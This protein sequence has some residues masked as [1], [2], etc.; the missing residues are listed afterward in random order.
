MD[1]V[2]AMGLKDSVL[3]FDKDKVKQ[4]I[5]ES[6]RK[7]IPPLEMADVLT[8]AI[9]EIGEGLQRGDMF[10]PE[11]M[12][13]AKTVS[14]GMDLLEQ[15]LTR[16]GQKRKILGRVVI[17]TVRGDLHD[18]G[19]NMVKTLM[20][21]NGFEVLDLGVNV[22]HSSFVE[23]A[24]NTKPNILAMSAL[25]TTTVSEMR[26]VIHALEQAG[27]RRELKVMVGGA[28]VTKEFANEIAADG[29]EPTATLAVEL[30][31]TLVGATAPAAL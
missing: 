11:L 18:I 26:K 30:A 4:L 23:A 3:K 13:G 14:S 17:G 15:E 16:R 22:S 28:P 5:E 12:L 21:A 2:I 9:R 25:L 10:L 6:L 29:Y 24:S 8:G 7:G 31:R 1:E 27:L 19:K 20:V